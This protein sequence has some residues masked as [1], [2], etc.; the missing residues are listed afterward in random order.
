MPT[1]RSKKKMMKRFALRVIFNGWFVISYLKNFG[2]TNTILFY[3]GLPDKGS[4][5]YKLVKILGCKI[6]NDPGKKH[7]LAIHWEDI[8]VRQPHL[9]LSE[10]NKKGPVINIH[11]RD[12]QQKPCERCF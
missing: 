5:I 10:L 6:T 12:Y 1:G 7:Q 4:V 3:P 8:T 11:C 2:K 9:V